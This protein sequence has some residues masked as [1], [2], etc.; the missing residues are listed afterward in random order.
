MRAKE[1]EYLLRNTGNS[2]KTITTRE[3]D[4]PQWYQDVISASD[5]AENGPA[6]GS[7]II[8]PYGY[9]IWEAI[10]AELDSRI[11]DLGVIFTKSFIHL[12]LHLKNV[13]INSN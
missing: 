11:K 10:K 6:K 12:T 1:F 7:M 2:K 3:S 8:K 13:E 5:L 4:F 9:A